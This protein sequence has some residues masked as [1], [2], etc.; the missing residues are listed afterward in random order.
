[1]R[2][3]LTFALLVATG[4]AAA[5]PLETTIDRLAKPYVDSETVVG[6]TVGIL[7]GDDQ[8]VRGYGRFS[9]DDSRT[10]DGKT[11]YEIGSLSKVFTGLL[12]ADAVVQGRVTLHT[13]VNQLLPKG[14]ELQPHGDQLAEL[15]HLS[16]H[17]S[18]LPR[19]PD[20]LAPSDPNNP[21]ADYDGKRLGA[22]LNSYR[23]RKRPCEVIEYSN[24][25]AGLLG[26]CLAREQKTDYASLLQKRIA[27]PLGLSDTT[28]K[29]DEERRD[30]LAPPHTEGGVPDHNWDFE[31]LAGAGA[32]RST[33]DDMLTFAKAFL[34]P[35]EGELREA[36]GLSWCV[37]QKPIEDSDFAM[38]LGW[39]VARDDQTR[40]HNGQT[41]GYHSALFINRPLKVAVVVLTNTATME[42][43]TLAQDLVRALAGADVK[44]R[45]FEVSDDVPAEV[46]ERY[47][48]KY[49][50]APG[51]EF[52]V[53]T[54][55]GKLLVGLT[56]QPTFQVFSRSETE[57]FYKVVEATLTFKV[58]GKG[59]CT[60]VELFQNGVRQ[61]A[62]RIE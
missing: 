41:G 20:N 46:L 8:A 13:P 4:T 26:L 50:L 25:G 58:D 43:D 57:W 12:L 42:V 40:W 51:A 34:D 17:T 15:W 49:R 14:V 33:A 23:P 55:G 32:I 21:Y 28:I 56:G 29:L 35:Q 47:V 39:H 38:G 19:L 48:G 52:T 62:E 37:H 61:T 60:A 5:E 6:M 53:T 31:T 27:K 59:N 45:E 10:P 1:M 22:F 54:K 18:G 11:V 9:A 3:P 7:R 16:T 44:P 2:L 30:R 24:L 36:I